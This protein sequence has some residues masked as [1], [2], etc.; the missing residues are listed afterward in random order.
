MDDLFSRFFE[1]ALLPFE[2]DY[3]KIRTWNQDVDDKGNEIVVGAE[4]PGFEANEID[5]QRGRTSPR[6]QSRLSS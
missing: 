1:Q 5:V 4:I 6:K 3:E 2:G